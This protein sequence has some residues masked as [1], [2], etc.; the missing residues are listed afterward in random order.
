MQN[1]WITQLK[2]LGIYGFISPLH[3]KDTEESGEIKK[4]HYHVLLNFSGVKS[5]EQVKEIS[6]SFNSPSPQYCQDWRGACRYLCHLDS[7]HKAQYDP[8]QVISLGGGSDYLEAIRIS[9]DKYRAI[10]EM[11]DFIRCQDIRSFAAMFDY[12]RENNEEW[13]R[14]LCDSCSYV[15]REYIKSYSYEM[16]Q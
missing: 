15:I 7:P 9:T 13:F 4:P 6:D 14:S 5:Y 11:M 8:S 1:E 2:D 3:D 16:K 10:S 12:C